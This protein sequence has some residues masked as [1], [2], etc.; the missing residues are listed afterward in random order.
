MAADSSPA[1]VRPPRTG[2]VRLAVAV[3]AAAVLVVLTAAG[4]RLTSTEAAFTDAG[5]ATGSFQVMTVVAPTSITCVSNADN[6][7]TIGWAYPNG[8]PT[9]FDILLGATGAT[10]LTTVPGTARSVTLTGQALLAL[11]T[12]QIR[13]RTNVAPTWPMPASASVGVNVISLLGLA[14]AACAT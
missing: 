8:T 2:R 4:P 1:G 10:V 5:G 7:V 14:A 11:G 13:I 12:F 3:L 9:Q 6:T